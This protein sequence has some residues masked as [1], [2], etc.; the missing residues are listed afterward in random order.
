MSTVRRVGIAGLG[1]Y[2][3]E[4]V[5]TNAELARTL[6]TSD[7]WIRTRTGIRERRIAAP[8][9]AA[10]DLGL[11]AAQR[12]LADAGVPAD[13]VDL[14]IV[15]SSTSDMQ[16]PATACLIQDRLGATRA[17][18]F[19]LSAVCSGF[20][21]ALA[22]GTQAVAAREAER[23]LVIAAEKFS[24]VLDW[25]DR[26]TSVLMGDGAGAALLTA[27]APRGEI[28]SNVLGADGTGIDLLYI[29]A[30]GSA[31]PTSHETVDQRLHYMKM[32]GR[33]IYKFGARIIGESV[34]KALLQAGLKE[35]DLDLLIPHQANIRI[36]E[37]AAARFNLPMDR[38][39]VNLDRYSN[40]SAA[41]VPIALA[42]AK[43]QGRLKPGMI[44][45]LVGFGAGLTWGASVLRW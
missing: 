22:T 30:G 3:P 16:F 39:V 13:A 26:A 9:Q 4:R 41:S 2:L 10:S 1:A 11:V 29:P 38:I 15:A 32:N 7:E 14:V 6:D 24:S 8:E 40:T 21:Y 43:E 37:S 19:D 35:T 42:E 18:A 17:G 28:L 45:G 36:L 44:V 12:A 23:V 33:E 31:R 20:S 5:V 27:D 34:S 25:Q